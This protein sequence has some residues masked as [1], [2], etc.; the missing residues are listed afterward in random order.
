MSN[1]SGKSIHTTGKTIAI[2][3]GT[4]WGNRGAEAMLVTT[5]GRIRRRHPDA[6]FMVFSYYPEK[7]ACLCS[8]STIEFYNLPAVEHRAKGISAGPACLG[9]WTDTDSSSRLDDRTGTQCNATGRC[10]V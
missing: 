5:I 1:E 9:I 2:V 10:T 6:R 8:D 3:G 7:D 4:L